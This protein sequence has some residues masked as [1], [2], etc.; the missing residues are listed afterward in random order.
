MIPESDLCRASPAFFARKASR[1]KWKPTRHHVVLLERLVDVGVG[2][3]KRLA[4]SMP[5]QNGKSTA[6]GVYGSAWYLGRFKADGGRKVIYTS[7]EGTL[8]ASFGR[9]AKAVLEEFGPSVF[10]VEVA[11]DSHRSDWWTIR[12]R[13][14]GRICGEM[15]TAGVRGAVGGKG[16]D[17][18]IVDDPYRGPDEANS[19]VV[20]ERVQ[21]WHDAVLVQRLSEVGGEIV[22]QTRWHENDLVGTLLERAKKDGG[23]PFVEVRFPAIAEATDRSPWEWRKPGEAL[24]P[25]K[26]PLA[27]LLRRRAVTPT[28]AWLALFQQRPSGATGTAFPKEHF[29]Y[30][31]L[32]FIGG[33]TVVT[34]DRSPDNLPPLTFRLKD[35]RIFVAIDLA[36]STREGADFTA[37]GIFARTPE[38]HLCWIDLVHERMEAPDQLP[39]VRALFSRWPTLMAGIEAVQYQRALVQQGLRLGLPVLPLEPHADKYTRSIPA[40]VLMR[41]HRIYFRSDLPKLYEVEKQLGEVVRGKKIEHDDL[42][43]VLAYGVLM[44][45]DTGPRIYSSAEEEEEAEAVEAAAKEIRDAFHAG[46]TKT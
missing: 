15:M 23:D 33:E 42:L 11:S 34:L 19:R 17:L 40:Q 30:C 46:P 31:K 35:C 16:A 6:L 2:R 36:L 9:K 4:T 22:S 45:M 38:G 10:G 12:D 5:P 44:G 8:A 1:G 18:A 13:A 39:L 32:E 27:W 3:I 43:D 25:A 7:Y 24:W 14:T 37:A 28:W 26:Y 29:R 20:R 41:G 21:E